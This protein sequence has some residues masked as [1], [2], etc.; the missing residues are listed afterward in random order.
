MPEILTTYEPDNSLKKGYSL[1]FSEI[2][3][4]IKKNR[5]LTYQLFKRDFFTLYKQTYMGIVWTLIIPVVSIVIFII[6]NSSGVF[7][8]GDIKT[9]YPVFAV[10]GMMFWQIFSGVLISASNSLANAGPM[11]V[12]INFSKKSLVIASLG[13]ALLSFVIQFILLA[14][15]FFIYEFPPR[16]E[17]V[18]MP[19]FVAPVLA[20]AL[21]LGF[22]FSLLN[23]IVRDVGNML[24]ILVTFLMF[25]TPVFYAKPSG[26]LLAIITQYNILYYLVSIPRELIL[27]GA[28][29]ELGGFLISSLSSFI[30]LIIC[31]VVFHLTETRIAERV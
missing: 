16:L 3:N 10:M 2:Y 19:V 1:V 12:K 22:L 4:D 24:S 8:S 5:W 23:A 7:S 27:F 18:L 9:P 14:V 31:L 21:G 6:L 20:L 28:T 11:I 26:G 25:L 17:I 29:S 30:L 15:L 13:K